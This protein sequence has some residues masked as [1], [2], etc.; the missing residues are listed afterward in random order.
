[1]MKQK[2]FAGVVLLVLALVATVFYLFPLVLVAINS[3]KTTGE[4]T[5]NPF[6][7]PTVPQWG[8]YAYAFGQMHFLTSM[9]NSLVITVSVCVLVSLLGAMAAYAV[10]R[11][12]HK[13]VSTVYYLMLASMCAPF[14]AYM[15]PLVK[16]YASQLG[17]NNSLIPVIYIGLGLNICFSIFLVRGF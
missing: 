7:M 4:F 2:R 8:N 14:Q 17:M 15:I 12:K 3:I 10:S 13:F 6:S 9:R 1:M 16:I 11:V 5:S